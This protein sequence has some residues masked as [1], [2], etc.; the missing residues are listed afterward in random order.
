LNSSKPV[1][2]DFFADWCPPCKKLAVLFEQELDSEGS[3]VLAKVKS[4]NPLN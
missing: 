3:W 2:V 1:I 4:D